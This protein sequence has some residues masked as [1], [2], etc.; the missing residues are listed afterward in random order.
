MSKKTDLL[1]RYES[2]LRGESGEWF[3]TEEYEEIA[4]E[5]EMTSML[6]DAIKAIETGLKYHPMSEELMTRRAYYLL[7]TGRIEEAEEVISVVT[8]KT[9]E[10][11]SIRAE[12]C[13]ISGETDD[14]IAII[15]DVLIDKTLQAEHI[16]N[17]IDLCAD[18]KLYENVTPSIFVAIDRLPRTQ[19]LSVLREFMKI[20]EEESEFQW[21]IKVVE[22]ILDIDPYS[23]IEWIKAIELYIYL[24]DIQKAFD[25]VEY[26]IA[27]EPSN[28]DAYYYKAYCFMEQAD[29]D[30]A[31]SILES[32]DKTKDENIYIMLATC[33]TKMYKFEDSNRVLKE[34]ENYFPISA[35]SLYISAQNCYKSSN[36]SNKAIELLNKAEEIEPY[37][38]DIVYMLAK[39]YY[40][41]EAYEKAKDA[42]TRLTYTD[43]DESDGRAYVIGGDIEIKCGSP[44]KALDY[45]KK[46]FALDKYDIDTCFKMIYTYSELHDVENMH[47]T[48]DYVEDLISNTN[49]ETLSDEEQCRLL[50]LRSAVD[51]IKDILRNHIEDI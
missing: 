29:Y 24:S 50:Y 7:I 41:Q 48:I 46:A 39:L 16:L 2:M 25:A 11:Q 35:K 21:Q 17:I 12:L 40:E 20:L 27:I 1:L 13:L 22:K 6:S 31:V 36:D 28:T 38:S 47:N 33:Y 18:Y 23:Y 34:S 49:I 45:Y 42:L 14:A 32:L 30:E 43:Y 44:E 8:D 9:E 19:K 15:K 10:A 3:D 5:Y 51:K 26:A 37:S 4:L